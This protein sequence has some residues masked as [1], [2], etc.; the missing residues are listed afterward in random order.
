MSEDKELVFLE[1]LRKY[2]NKWVA[3]F[4]S[5]DEE[6]VVGSGANAVE[7]QREAEA[8]GFKNTVLFWVKPFNMGYMPLTCS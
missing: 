8:K 3:I 2:E 1:Q 6:I 5:D 4:E 7:A